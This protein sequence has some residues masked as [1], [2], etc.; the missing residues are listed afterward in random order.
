M[1][2][3]PGS[4]GSIKAVRELL[5]AHD[6]DGVITLSQLE[7]LKSRMIAQKR[8]EQLDLP[9][10]TEDRRPL[11]AAGVAILIALFQG[12]GIERMDYSDGALREGLLYE[13]NSGSN[14]RIFARARRLVLPIS[15]SSTS[16]KPR[17][18]RPLPC[19]CL[20]RLQPAGSWTPNLSSP[21][22]LGGHAPRNRPLPSTTPPS[23]AILPTY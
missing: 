22:V 16:S 7:Q 23:S 14:I 4:S 18:L 21:A 11:I 3:L 19:N 15:T 8:I 9:G 13:L 20:I 5:V 12:L 1:G 10:L 2:K 6:D 17:G